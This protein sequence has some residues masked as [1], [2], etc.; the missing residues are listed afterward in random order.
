VKI[1]VFELPDKVYF[2]D[3][4]RSSIP[5]HCWGDLL[6]NPTLLI[7]CLSMLGIV[8][9]KFS[10][11]FTHGVIIP[12]DFQNEA[13]INFYHVFDQQ[14]NEYKFFYACCLMLTQ[15]KSMKTCCIFPQG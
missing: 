12:F 14:S 13:A 8:F 2:L 9:S 3:T 5:E 11:H 10:P 7:I 15:Y 4:V 6:T 1:N